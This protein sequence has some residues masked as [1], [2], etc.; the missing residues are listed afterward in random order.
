ML[1]DSLYLGFDFIGEFWFGTELTTWIAIYF[2]MAY[3]KK[4]CMEW[5][6]SIKSNQW[7]KNNNP[8]LFMIAV[9]L[10]NIART[11]R[12]SNDAVNCISGLTLLIYIVHENLILRTYYRPAMANYVYEHYDYDHI[13]VWVLI[14]AAVIF[15]FSMLAASFYK[16]TL[17]K[18]VKMPA[19]I[20]FWTTFYI[21]CYSSN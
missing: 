1:H 3:L 6:D 5:M 7:V 17:E 15:L 18:I 19:Q 21:C 9:G 10:F 13:I 12:F 14:L 16:Q 4:Y 8:F 20:P 11:V 2:T